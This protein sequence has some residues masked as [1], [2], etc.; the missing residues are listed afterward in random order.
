MIYDPANY[1]DWEWR[2][3]NTLLFSDPVLYSWLQWETENARDSLWKRTEIRFEP[4]E[5]TALLPLRYGLYGR[6]ERS[7]FVYPPV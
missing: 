2:R 5:L 6:A 4:L 7:P 1:N 3:V